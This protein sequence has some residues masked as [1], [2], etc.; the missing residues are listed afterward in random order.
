MA[1]TDNSYCTE[2]HVTQITRSPYTTTTVPTEA[3]MLIFTENRSAEVYNRLVKFMGASATGPSGYATSIDT[4]TDAGLAMDFVTRQ[5]AAIG[6]AIDCLDAAGAGE[7]PG[8]SERIIDLTALHEIAMER[9]E[10]AAIA[11]IGK[12]ARSETHISSGDVTVP[13]RVVVEQQGI[14]FNSETEF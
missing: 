12:A 4:S 1:T 9:L 14:I 10:D 8:R 13:T 3:E 7:S 11:Y 5:A 6:A 2:A